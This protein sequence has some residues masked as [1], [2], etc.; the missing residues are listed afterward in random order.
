MGIMLLL[1]NI[2]FITVFIKT[3]ELF[4]LVILPMD[5]G[6]VIWYNPWTKIIISENSI[7]EQGIFRKKEIVFN[8]IKQVSI[9][10]T[11]RASSF[12]DVNEVLSNPF[13]IYQICVLKEKLGSPPSEYIEISNKDY[14]QFDFRPEAYQQL[15]NINR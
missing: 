6:F 2:I 3:G 9:I 5:V 12:V 1:F 11:Q 4:T 13:A 7:I 8:Q 15:K 14:I 10:A